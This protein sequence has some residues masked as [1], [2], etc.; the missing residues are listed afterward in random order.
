MT[1]GTLFVLAILAL[2]VGY[3]IKKA[4]KNRGKGSCSSCPSS[5]H[6][7]SHCGGTDA[8]S[9]HIDQKKLDEIKSEHRHRHAEGSCSCCHEQDGDR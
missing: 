2:I 1:P 9:I 7:C 6:G 4:W 3:T 5:K 8:D